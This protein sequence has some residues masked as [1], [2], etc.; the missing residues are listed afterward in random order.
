MPPRKFDQGL[1][2]PTEALKAFYTMPPPPSA[3]ASATE[4]ATYKAR[5]SDI[6]SRKA[7]LEKYPEA[8]APILAALNSQ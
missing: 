6:A 3:N 2:S 1:P 7:V 4:L 5:V 8:A